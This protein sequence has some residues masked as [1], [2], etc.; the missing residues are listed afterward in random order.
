MRDAFSEFMVRAWNSFQE[1]L[2]ANTL[3]TAVSILATVAAIIGAVYFTLRRDGKAAMLV[4][5]KEEWWTVTRIGFFVI[6][7]VHGPLFIWK[8]LLVTLQTD[9]LALKN[10]TS[11]NQRLKLE[12]D[13]HRHAIS[14]RDPVFPN[15]IYLLQ[16]FRMY[17]VA[18]GPSTRCTVYVTSP[19]DSAA[20]A[21][22]VAQLQIAVSNCATFGPMGTDM[23]AL[24]KE[25]L[26][27]STPGFITVNA[28]ENSKAADELAA[29]LS[30][31]FKV[32]RGYKEI[33]KGRLADIV[34]EQVWL[35]FGE[36]TRFASELR[37]R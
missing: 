9:Q 3:S 12:L 22:M 33:P 16:A 32:K 37:Q 8:G 17:R 35:Q 24:S 4:R 23:P 36:N 15:T 26:E 27:G 14:T 34:P 18:L 30:P 10:A 25:A 6:V 19:P 13:A 20:T 7:V 21:S 31:H 28:R 5:L 11:E 1:A 29:R 2:G